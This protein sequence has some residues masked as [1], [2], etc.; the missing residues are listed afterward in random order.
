MFK[1]VLI[2]PVELEFVQ[3][4]EDN[5]K[6]VY[7]EVASQ[8]TNIKASRD[9]YDESCLD[10]PISKKITIMC[11]LGDYIIKDPNPKNGYKFYSCD[12][13]VFERLMTT[14]G[15]KL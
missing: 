7:D 8:Q 6:Q 2:N 1:K 10:I 13:D 4:T 3:F 12:A 9:E 14:F 11:H 15:V 5:K